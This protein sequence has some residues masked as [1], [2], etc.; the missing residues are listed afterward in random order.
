MKKTWYQLIKLYE[1]ASV[2][3]HDDKLEFMNRCDITQNEFMVVHVKY[4]MN[5]FQEPN[6]RNKLAI[7]IVIGVL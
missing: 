7:P 2:N 1:K 5:E 6:G 3:S 4:F